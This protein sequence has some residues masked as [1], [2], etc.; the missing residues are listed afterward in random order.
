MSEKQLISKLSKVGN[1]I[2]LLK[3]FKD[4][5]NFIAEHQDNFPKNE[6][7]DTIYLDLSGDFYKVIGKTIKSTSEISSGY[8]MKLSHTGLEQLK[9]T[10]GLQSNHDMDLVFKELRRAKNIK[11]YKSILT[12]IDGEFST[13]ISVSKLATLGFKSLFGK[14]A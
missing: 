3:M 1:P 9:T 13:N 6:A 10:L 7:D 4:V 11:N 5:K 12:A 8:M 14:E 2:T